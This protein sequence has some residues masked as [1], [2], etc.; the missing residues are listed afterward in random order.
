[1]VERMKKSQCF[2]V[3]QKMSCITC[4]NPHVSVKQ[5]ALSSFNQSCNNCHNKASAGLCTETLQN[6]ARQEDNCVGCHMPKNGSIDIPHVAV[7]DHFIRKNPAN[8][9]SKG[10]IEAFLGL[11]SFNNPNPD[12]ITIGRGYL[13]FYERFNATE[14]LLDSA[15]LYISKNLKEEEKKY[16]NKNLIRAY[17]LKKDYPKV[18]GLVENIS[19]G[20]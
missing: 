9:E 10:K 17:F 2:I 11:R 8:D 20:T 19:A 6:R 13:E 7:T 3:S 16:K 14:F 18:T 15:L 1:H 4:H 5:T 12:A